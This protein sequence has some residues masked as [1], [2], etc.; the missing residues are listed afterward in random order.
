MSENPFNYMEKHRYISLTTFYK[1]GKG[2][3][4]PVEFAEKDGKLYVN[5]R[6][7]SWKGKRIR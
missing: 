2:V 5:T 4:T 3:T 6:K 1:S 7:E